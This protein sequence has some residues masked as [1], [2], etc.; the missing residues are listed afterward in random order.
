MSTR[1]VVFRG[2]PTGRIADALALQQQ[3][4]HKRAERIY[5]R[6]L[7]AD[8]AN[9][10]A[11]HLLGLLRHQ[12]GRSDEGLSLVRR[13]IQYAP[14]EPTLYLNAGVILESRRCYAQ[15]LAAYRRAA[16]LG[17]KDMYPW[18]NLGVTWG[19]LNEYAVSAQY[20][21]KALEVAPTTV[22]ALDNLIYSLDL[23]PD[24]TPERRHDVRRRWNDTF[25]VDVAR[26]RAPH[27]NDPDPERKL[28]IGYVSADFR[29]HSAWLTFSPVMLEHDRD[30]FDVY[31]YSGWADDGD[32]ATDMIRDA[33][34]HW[35]NT[36]AQDDASVAQMIRDD[37]IDILVDLSGFTAGNRML[38]FARKPAPIQ[39]SGWGYATGLSLDHMDGFFTDPVATPPDWHGQQVDEEL[40]YLPCV[41]A[42]N[43]PADAMPVNDLPARTYGCVTFGSFNQPKKLSTPTL[44]LWAR[45]LKAVPGARMVLKH[46]GLEVPEV[47]ERI[48]QH[49]EEEGVDTGRLHLFGHSPHHHHVAAFRDVD[50]QLDPTPHGGGVTTFEGLMMGVPCLTMTG[51]RVSARISV[52]IMTH[53]G[54]PEWVA[55]S[56]DEYVEKAARFAAD[57][58]ALAE[59]RAGLRDRL[60]ASPMV[61]H[62]VVDG[63]MI[64]TGRTYCAAVEGHYRA[65][66]RR[67]TEGKVREAA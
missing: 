24:A 58:D 31:A 62:A 15:A 49:F 54:M 10:Q 28:R 19:S 4:D 5:E 30:R 2:S 39:V 3:G 36:A 55:E 53:L 50:I 48:R 63:T 51:D 34:V 17:P 21:E 11:L 43:P 22:S 47:E 46:A 6:V 35:R 23:D 56:E 18:F 13:A 64:R 38:V 60:L 20:F 1:K 59:T 52:S 7:R 33:G 65:L 67:W 57:L 45:V 9:V 61:E 41:I 37:G 40:L 16:K 32:A 44:K 12:Q 27:A 8:P 29:Q 26:E 66:W 25:A 14:T 42:Y